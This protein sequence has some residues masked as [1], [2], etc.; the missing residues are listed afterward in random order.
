MT[1][2]TGKAEVPTA[3]GVRV[4]QLSGPIPPDIALQEAQQELDKNF[5][6]QYLETM[7][8]LREKGFSYREIASWL[9]ERGVDVDHNEVYRVYMEYG[10]HGAPVNDALAEDAAYAAEQ[11]AAEENGKGQNEGTSAKSESASGGSVK[12]EAKGRTSGEGKQRG[13]GN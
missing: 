5:L 7:H 4:V 1:A 9:A 13:T 12:S 6:L 11:R 8:V 10:V 2:M 3:P